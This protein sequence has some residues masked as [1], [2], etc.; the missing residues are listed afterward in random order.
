[1]VKE[2]ETKAYTQE[3]NSVSDPVETVF[4]LSHP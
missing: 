4:W 3:I 1:M 2:F